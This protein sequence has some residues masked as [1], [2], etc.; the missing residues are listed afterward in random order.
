VAIVGFVA[1]Y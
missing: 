1:K